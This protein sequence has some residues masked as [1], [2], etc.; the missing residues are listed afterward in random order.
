MYITSV[1]YSWIGCEGYLTNI[2]KPVML[3]TLNFQFPQRPYIPAPLNGTGC[4]Y[5]SQSWG[6]SAP[7]PAHAFCFPAQWDQLL[8]QVF[9]RLGSLV[10]EQHALQHA[11]QEH[12]VNHSLKYWPL[13]SR[14]KQFLLHLCCMCFGLKTLTVGIQRWGTGDGH[15]TSKQFKS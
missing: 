10:T 8:S 5:E 3:F 2:I 15:K 4:L 12:G 13:S 7:P 6:C 1:S 9:K 14:M 11:I